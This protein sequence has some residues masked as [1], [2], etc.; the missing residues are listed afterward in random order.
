MAC[1]TCE[2]LG[3]SNRTMS[4]LIAYPRYFKAIGGNRPL[5]ALYNNLGVDQYGA[6][7]HPAPAFVA[8][9]TVCLLSHRLS[10][11]LDP[12]APAPIAVR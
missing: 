1:G 12:L 8:I 2:L 10:V 4:S 3:F 7:L 9:P 11:V 6:C 5:C